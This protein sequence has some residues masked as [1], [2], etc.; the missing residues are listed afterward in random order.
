MLF[1]NKL[2]LFGASLFSMTVIMAEKFTPA[3]LIQLPRPGVPVTSPSGALAV[4]AQS[5]YNITEAKTVRNL[6]LLNIDN[7]SV[8]EL[9][10]PSFDTSDSEP[11]FLDDQHIAYF[12]HDNELKED[13]DQLYVIDLEN[14]QE[15]PYR[16]T[17]F[18]ISFGNLKYNAQ[19]KL[20]AFS[21]SV[22][23]DDGTLEGTLKKDKEIKETKKDT[24]LVYDELMVRHWDDYVKEK[25]NN[26]F[27]VDVSII[28]RK[29]KIAS[30]PINLLRKT[31]LES[32]GFPMGDAS[33]FDI[34]P[35]ASQ[36]AFLA[37]INTRDN[38]WQT[39]AHI[40]TVATNGKGAPVAIN[41]DI[42][43][44]SSAPHFISSGL[45][46][47]FQM[48][49]PQ[50]ESDRNRIVVFNPKSGERKVIA[51]SWDSSPH[52]VTS[53]ADGKTLYVT[54]EQ[55]GRNKI[56]AVN[57]DTGSVKTLTEEHYATGLTV[58][59]SG[60]IFYGLSSMKHPVA[61]HV[62]DVS[63]KEIK[64]LAVESGLA[65][66]LKTIEFSE[67]EELRFTGALND[68][69]HGW[70]LK[71]ADFEEGKKYPVAFLIHGGPQ[72]AWN[73]NWSTRWNPQIF[74]G[75]GYA[76]VALNPHGSTGYGQAFTDSITRNWGS[77]PFEDLEK[78]LDHVLEKYSYLDAER[79]AGLGGSYGGYM[80]NWINGH[81]DKFKVLVN[82]DGVFS[83]THVYYTTDEIYFDEREFGG[84]PI[85][86]ENREGFEKWSPS[87]YVQ[88][89]KTPMLVIHGGNDFRLT[90][91]E[92]L[93][94]FTALQRQGIPS[95]LLYFPDESHWVLKPANSLRWHKEGNVVN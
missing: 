4:Y 75:A 8:E 48:M 41:K 14:K 77:Y 68:Q 81:S 52:E 12:H 94:T 10:K 40:Y 19:H 11:F 44:A 1:K 82:H 95:R 76:V 34:S 61:P 7:N 27:V 21:A 85:Q 54:A 49:V 18:P 80:T 26:I 16:L 38:A 33:D 46:V 36:I 67:P 57:I 63:T 93:S 15:S 35:D 64:P 91:D 71:P 88:N 66:K 6:Y 28:D 90:F 20:L 37:K 55:Q 29:Y 65:E 87:N 78:G 42:P 30:E 58:L 32:P 74:A 3:D 83:T 31:G 47:Y 17:D 62:L 25:K 92:S 69:V 89:W 43:A 53:S 79:V 56:F 13:V 73:D 24:A 2:L 39:S 45:L 22:Y 50:Y 60:N 86:P 23:N 70:Y 72:G 84:S 9:T 51:D 5:A 59:P